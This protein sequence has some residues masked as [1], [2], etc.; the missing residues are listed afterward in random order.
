MENFSTTIGS[1]SHPDIIDGVELH[2]VQS[3]YI[4]TVASYLKSGLY[5]HFDIKIV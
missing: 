2:A 4:N 3:I 1:I 5:D